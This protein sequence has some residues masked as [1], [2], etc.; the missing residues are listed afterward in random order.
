[1]LKPQ[2]KDKL[3]TSPP[4]PCHSTKHEKFFSHVPLLNY[5]SLFKRFFELKTRSQKVIQKLEKVMSLF[6]PRLHLPNVNKVDMLAGSGCTFGTCWWWCDDANDHLKITQ[7]DMKTVIHYSP[8]SHFRITVNLIR[9]D[10][11]LKNA[12]F[13]NS[14]LCDMFALTELFFSMDENFFH[15]FVLGLNRWKIFFSNAKWNIIIIRPSSPL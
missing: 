8:L 6:L 11:K 1:L 13:N 4:P 3:K 9:V 2:T 7:N 12:S 10:L 15:T 5:S 14:T